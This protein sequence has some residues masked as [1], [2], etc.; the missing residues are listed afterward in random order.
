MIRPPGMK[1]KFSK[2]QKN[3]FSHSLLLRGFDGCKLSCDSSPHLDR[4]P[5]NNRTTF[6]LESIFFIEHPST[7]LIVV[8]ELKRLIWEDDRCWS[9]LLQLVWCFSWI[10]DF[11]WYFSAKCIC[12]H[13]YILPIFSF[14]FLPFFVLNE[15]S[16]FTCSMYS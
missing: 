11:I 15:F 8:E 16:N 9:L 4:C 6:V 7:Q 13:Y 14:S 1:R 5:F 12:G 3:F 2:S 10:L